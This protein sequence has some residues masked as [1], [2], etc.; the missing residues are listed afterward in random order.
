VALRVIFVNTK[1]DFNLFNAMR[2]VDDTSEE[3]MYLIDSISR[4]YEK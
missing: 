3:P 4:R 2:C 1:H